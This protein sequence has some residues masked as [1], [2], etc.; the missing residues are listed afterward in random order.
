MRNA[1][2]ESEHPSYVSFNTVKII[3]VAIIID[4]HDD[5]DEKS[6]WR[7]ASLAITSLSI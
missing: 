3:T 7:L 5:N 1:H 6:S 2:E 4:H